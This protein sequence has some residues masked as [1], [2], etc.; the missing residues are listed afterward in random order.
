MK[1]LK[2]GGHTFELIIKSLGDNSPI[3]GETDFNKRT[4]TID[5]ETSLSYKE[6]TL[7]H[8]FIHASN[9]TLDG[10][11]IGHIFLD[12]LA[13]QLYQILSDNGLLN[14]E[15]FLELFSEDKA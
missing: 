4:I 11:E 10:N 5:G 3:I 12:S 15:A 2:I 9:T 1:T 13:E 14:K 7:I 6:S 8:E